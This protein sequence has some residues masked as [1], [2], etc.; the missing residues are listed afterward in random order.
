MKTKEI[1][2]ALGEGG[3]KYY[4]LPIMP[5][6]QEGNAKQC[7]IHKTKMWRSTLLNWNIS[8]LT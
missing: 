4:L 1:M 5:I 8:I 2:Y 3:V 6:M 7:T